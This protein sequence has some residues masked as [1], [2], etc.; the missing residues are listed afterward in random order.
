MALL[1]LPHLSSL[2]LWGPR[3]ADSPTYHPSYLSRPARPDIRLEN[4]ESFEYF[5]EK[6]R[7][8]SPVYCHQPSPFPPSGPRPITGRADG[9][10]PGV[11]TPV[12]LLHP[13][14]T[15]IRRVDVIFLEKSR[16]PLPVDVY[17]LISQTCKSPERCWAAKS[18]GNLIMWFHT[19]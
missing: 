8:K 3:P 4:T 18:I 2:P 19:V 16:C 1:A 14:I 10:A 15:T 7:S 13:N 12:M 5:H 9:P 11:V 17:P 6:E